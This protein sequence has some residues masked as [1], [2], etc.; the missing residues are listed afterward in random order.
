MD[1]L[2]LFG[3]AFLAATIFPAQSEAVLLLMQANGVASGM[4]LLAVASLGNTLGACVN[5][6]MGRFATGLRDRSWFPASSRQLQRAERWYARWG[7]WSLLLSWVPFVGDPLTVIAGLLRTPFLIFAVIVA[8][9][10]TSR[11]AVLLW[12]GAGM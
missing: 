10:K 7:V 12:L 2:I 6:G 8:V 1:L 3:S 9:A 4:V 5:W 11:Y